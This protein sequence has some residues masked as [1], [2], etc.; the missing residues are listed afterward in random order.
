MGAARG[1]IDLHQFFFGGVCLGTAFARPKDANGLQIIERKRC[2]PALGRFGRR[3]RR[4]GTAS[5]RSRR[6][7]LIQPIE[8]VQRADGEFGIGRVDQHGKLDL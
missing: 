3:A 2:A 4:F 5:C 1:V 7:L 8:A 6:G